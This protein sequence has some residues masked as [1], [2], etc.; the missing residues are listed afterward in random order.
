MERLDLAENLKNALAGA[1]HEFSELGAQVRR[2]PAYLKRYV[3]VPTELRVSESLGYCSAQVVYYP[4]EDI[5][6]VEVEEGESKIRWGGFLSSYPL[7]SAQEIGTPYGI[8]ALVKAIKRLSG[9]L[10]EALKAAWEGFTLDYR[11]VESVIQG[12]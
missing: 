5:L 1:L 6:I 2:P 12:E 3:T 11:M 7:L 8:A 10:R 9:H 4:L